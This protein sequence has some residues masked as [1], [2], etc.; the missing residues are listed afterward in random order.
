MTSNPEATIRQEARTALERMHA[1]EPDT[2]ARES[3]LGSMLNF[4]EAVE[5]ARRLVDLYRK[6]PVSV[7]DDL[8]QNQLQQLRDR[9]NTDFGK[10][11][12]IQKFSPRQNNATGVH[13]SLVNQLRANYQGAF[14]TLFLW[15]AYS[16]HKTADFGAL[17]NQARATVEAIQSN[18][19]SHMQAIAAT[20][21]AAEELLTSVRKIAAEHGVTQQA[22]YF[23]ESAERHEE[24][25]ST[26]QAVTKKL[27]IWLGIYAFLTLFLHKIPWVTPDDGYQTTQMAVSKI[28]V[29]A[30]MSFMLYLAARNMMSHRHNGIID[31]HRQNALLTYEALVK[32]AGDTPNREVILVQAAAC[33]FGPQ[34]TGYSRDNV[35]QPPGAQSVVEFM[36]RAGGASD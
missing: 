5:P 30:V 15:I 1:I 11:S 22:M 16:L 25:A 8:P 9:A 18:V 33:I 35:P 29:F 20:K 14:D 26:W 27:A 4:R 36:S 28:L 17:E 19:G 32:A 34:G 24:E 6:L 23:R 10:I 13:E 3:E 12:E 2:L 7:L 21:S 31:R